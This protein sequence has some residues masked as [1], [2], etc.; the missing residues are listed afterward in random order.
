MSFTQVFGVIVGVT[1]TIPQEMNLLQQLIFEFKRQCWVL[2]VFHFFHFVFGLS[3]LGRQQIF[4][5]FYKEDFAEEFLK[6]LVSYNFS[7]LFNA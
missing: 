6:Q 5:L 1:L 3:E 7:P 4:S 2:D